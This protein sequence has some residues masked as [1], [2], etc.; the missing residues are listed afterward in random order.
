MAENIRLSFVID[1]KGGKKLSGELR[2]AGKELDKLTGNTRKYTRQTRSAAQ[3]SD[4][5]R[6]SIR[7]AHRHVLRVYPR[8]HGGT[9]SGYIHPLAS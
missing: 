5:M 8:A 9:P 6:D 1:A 4:K 2:I 3:A 7:G